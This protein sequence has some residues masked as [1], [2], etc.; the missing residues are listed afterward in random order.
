MA[1]SSKRKSGDNSAPAGRRKRTAT[2]AAQPTTVP[3]SANPYAP[4]ANF[5]WGNKE[6][7]PDVEFSGS[8]KVWGTSSNAHTRRIRES[9][10]RLLGPPLAWEHAKDWKR[11]KV[12]R[13]L[14]AG[15]KEQEHATATGRAIAT[16][17]AQLTDV[18]RGKF[19]RLVHKTWETMLVQKK[20]YI[21]YRW[22]KLADTQKRFYLELRESDS[23]PAFTIPESYLQQTGIPPVQDFSVVISIDPINRQAYVRF[24]GP[25]ERDNGPNAQD[26]ALAI[27]NRLCRVEVAVAEG[28]G[29]DCYTDEEVGSDIDALS[30]LFLPLPTIG[31]GKLI[32]NCIA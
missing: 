27:A 23:L 28:G 25:V 26:P 19:E 17:K 1:G 13:S 8:R 31:L 14:R 6:F 9:Q 20:G 7:N 16:T 30:Y 29:D 22:Y 3:D 10:R 5:A 21:L 12:T 4:Y 24:E 18:Q 2:A 15:I 11:Q 32:D